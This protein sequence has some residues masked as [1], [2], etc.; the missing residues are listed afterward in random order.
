MIGGQIADYYFLFSLNR[1]VIICLGD[2][3]AYETPNLY[4]SI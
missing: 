3:Y 4:Q 2:S 1:E